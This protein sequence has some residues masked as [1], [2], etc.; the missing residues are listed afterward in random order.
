MNSLLSEKAIDIIRAALPI[1]AKKGFH[2]ATV[3]EIAQK[4]S[5]AKGTLYLYF[6][7]K[8]DLFTQMVTYV[9]RQISQAI[10]QKVEKAEDTWEKLEIAM[11]IHFSCLLKY[12]SSYLVSEMGAAQARIDHEAI[13]QA[14]IEHIKI[15]EQILRDHFDQL[16][17]HPPYSLRTASIIILGGLT[18]YIYKR[19]F[20][21]DFVPEPQEY[22]ETFKRFVRSALLAE[23]QTKT[24]KKSIKGKG[25]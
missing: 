13:R 17:T 7:S 14:K 6:D 19:Y 21:K 4:A 12:K 23:R 25:R 22:L 16:G 15:Y 18:N 1:F 10:I 9:S 11:D 20:L 8:E 5:V 2:S 24:K 3:D